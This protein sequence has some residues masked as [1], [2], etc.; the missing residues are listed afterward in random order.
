VLTGSG[1]AAGPEM[2]VTNAH[3][4]AGTRRIVVRDGRRD[5]TATPVL[6]D[7]HTDIAVLH[8]D[9]LEASPLDLATGVA[10]RGSGGAILG[11]PGGGPLDVAAGAVLQATEARGRDIYDAEPATRS[12][13]VLQ[14]QVR[15]G[16]S[17]G[18]FVLADGRVAGVVFAR[19]VS[20][21]DVAYALRASELVPE[22]QAAG[23]RTEAVDTGA[24]ASE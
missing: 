1:F 2:V 11:Y 9:D 17:G 7:P 10:P 15:P 23:G 14:G 22:L 5:R 24:C 12:I 18:P 21:A 8:V 4:I 6:L 16:N 20:D 13:Y 19:S 3:V